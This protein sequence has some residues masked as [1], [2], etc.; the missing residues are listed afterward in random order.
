MGLAAAALL[1]AGQS[2]TEQWWPFGWWP[3]VAGALFAAV[4]VVSARDFARAE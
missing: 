1:F 3:L 2:L 4:A